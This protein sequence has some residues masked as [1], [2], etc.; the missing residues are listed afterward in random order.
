M[1][2][3]Y[4]VNLPCKPYVKRWLI[5]VGGDPVELAE[6]KDLQQLFRTHLQRG[7]REEPAKP[8]LNSV[9]YTETVSIATT[10]DDFYRHGYFLSRNSILEINKW[11][12]VRVKFNARQFILLNN[13][14][15]VP[16]AGCIREFQEQFGYYEHIWSFEAI[17][18]DYDRNGNKLL[19]FKAIQILK[20][21][22]NEIVLLNLKDAGIISEE[23]IIKLQ[24]LHNENKAFQLQDSGFIEETSS[25]QPPIDLE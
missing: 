2:E 24:K 7:V 11:I 15:G 25:D 6:A 3:V 16:V 17:K 10:E 4:L 9:H 12:E 23:G 5:S 14:L 22:I 21:A 20:R 13:A 8:D 19:Q 1:N 18:K